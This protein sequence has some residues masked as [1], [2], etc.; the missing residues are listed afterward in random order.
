MERRDVQHQPRQT[1]PTEIKVFLVIG[2]PTK[3]KQTTLSDKISADK[4]AENLALC[5]KFRP[6]KNFVRRKLCPPKYFNPTTSDGRKHDGKKNY[7]QLDFK[8]NVWRTNIFGGQ[9]C[10]NFDL[11][12]K[13]LSAEK[14]CPPKFCPIRY[15]PPVYLAV[16]SRAPIFQR[17]DSN[18]SKRTL[19][20]CITIR[21]LD[22]SPKYDL[23]KSLP[24]FQTFYLFSF[25]Q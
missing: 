14:F 21:K 6:P 19:R 13:I 15:P 1:K 9:K 16:E 20:F 10:R 7:D 25:Y 5:R 8:K 22:N 24:D 23:P 18:Y 12:P 17:P 4:S 3:T 11:V 2:G